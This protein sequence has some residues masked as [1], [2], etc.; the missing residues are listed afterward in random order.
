MNLT[1][2]IISILLIGTS[3][4]SYSQQKKNTVI[5]PTPNL[6]GVGNFMV[7]LNFKPFGSGDVISFENL[8]T[9]FRITDNISLR[10]GLKIENQ[11]NSQQHED[12]ASTEKYPYT[13]S[14]HSLLFGIKPG[15]E[16]HFLKNRKI[17]PYVG[18]ELT[19][20]NKSSDS[21]Y[22]GYSQSYNGNTGANQYTYQKYTIDGAWRGVGTSTYVS[23]GTTYNYN[24]ITY[25]NQRAYKSVGGNLLFGSDFYFIKN[26]YFGFE[27]GLG[28]NNIKYEQIKIEDSNT[29]EKTTYPSYNSSNL[30]FYYNNSIR[31][32][33]WF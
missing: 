9:K 4:A 30:N 32:G 5:E 16:Y 14:E 15:I 13:A 6:P 29:V 19:Y 22:D 8:Q 28:Y 12:F 21:E 1:R 17:S 2:K 18:C 24:Y 20:F 3:L 10:L 31:L 33:I 26:L 27:I 23:N 25:T 11:N 7:E